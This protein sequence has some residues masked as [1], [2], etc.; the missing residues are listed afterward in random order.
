MNDE[1]L[2]EITDFCSECIGKDCCP[3]EECILF[4]I[5]QI[6]LKKDDSNTSIKL[7]NDSN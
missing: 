2:T 1:I 7:V 4:R 6:L 5:E 3:E